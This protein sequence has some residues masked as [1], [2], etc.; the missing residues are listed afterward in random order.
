MLS[1]MKF[2]FLFQKTAKMNPL[3]FGTL[4]FFV[5]L[6]AISI[7]DEDLTKASETETAATKT[8]NESV[9]GHPFLKQDFYDEAEP[10]YTNEI[11]D[12]WTFYRQ[13]RGPSGFSA[14]RG[15][16]SYDARDNWEYDVNELK[17]CG[18]IKLISI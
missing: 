9:T 6:P 4:T 18:K 15:K 10:D 8:E 3:F 13:L 1:D 5:F 11:N 7:C 17:F 2:D 14:V 16:K 12:P